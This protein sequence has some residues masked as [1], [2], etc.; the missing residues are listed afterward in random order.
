MYTFSSSN[1]QCQF[2]SNINTGYGHLMLSSSK[3]FLLGIDSTNILHMY[4]ITFSNTAVDWANRITCSSATWSISYSE[5]L[6]ST[7]GTTI[8]SSFAYGPT[9]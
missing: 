6:M 1:A 8:F 2:I 5:S 9:I 3:L 4:K 7:D